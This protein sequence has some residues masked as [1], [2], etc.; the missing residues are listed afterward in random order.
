MTEPLG[1]PVHLFTKEERARRRRLVAIAVVVLG[2][3]AVLLTVVALNVATKPNTDVHLG[4]TT[5]KVGRASTLAKRITADDYPLLFQDL[6]DN[7]IDVY[8]QHLGTNHLTRWRA[9][10]AHAP[11]A[12]RRCQLS[13]TGAEFRDPCD[14][15]VF[16]AD[17]TG[18]RRFQVNVVSGVVYVNFREV[19][20]PAE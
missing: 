8:V 3:F 15:T 16:P 9:I 13:W 18:L 4:S 7:S 17:G 6:Q 14:G 5:F 2:G 12:P 1:P 10:E 11:D 20:E 19:I